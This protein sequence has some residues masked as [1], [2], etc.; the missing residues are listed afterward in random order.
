MSQNR[1][2]SAPTASSPDGP[3]E[4]GSEPKGPHRCMTERP[5]RASP[6]DRADATFGAVRGY[7]L[8]DSR[9]HLIMSAAKGDVVIRRSSRGTFTL[10]LYP[11]PA[12]ISVASYPEALRLAEGFSKKAKLAVWYVNNDGEFTAVSS[13]PQ[14]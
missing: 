6:G 8:L 3:R 11:E 2:H 13:V 5:P 1:T 7:G 12:Q 4:I 14:S 9:G 10:E